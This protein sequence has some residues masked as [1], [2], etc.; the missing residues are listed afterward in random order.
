MDYLLSFSA[1]EQTIALGLLLLAVVLL[2]LLQGWNEMDRGAEEEP[3][4]HSPI[5]KLYPVRTNNTD[6]GDLP[7]IR[8]SE[9]DDDSIDDEEE[10]WEHQF[11]RAVKES[12]RRKREEKSC[13]RT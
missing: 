6:G 7:P 1:Q 8:L 5:V 12:R 3:E 13:K 9:G 11:S 2:S 4:S 10:E